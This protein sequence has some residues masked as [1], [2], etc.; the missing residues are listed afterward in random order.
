MSAIEDVFAQLETL[1]DEYL[2]LMDS[3]IRDCRAAYGASSLVEW[4][5]G[6]NE[7][8][9]EIF[10]RMFRG[11]ACQKQAVEMFIRPVELWNEAA[12]RDESTQKRLMDSMLEEMQALQNVSSLSWKDRREALDETVDDQMVLMLKNDERVAGWSAKAISEVLQCHVSTVKKSPSW[13]VY[14]AYRTM[15]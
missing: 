4:F 9:R 6:L 8:Q 15:R 12:S 10:L 2:L 11:K 3:V 5:G 13:K 1:P 14:L 7:L